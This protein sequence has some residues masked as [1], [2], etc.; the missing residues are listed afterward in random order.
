MYLHK[1][2]DIYTISLESY[3]KQRSPKLLKE[4]LY[5]VDRKIITP[6][7]MLKYQLSWP[8]IFARIQRKA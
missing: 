6:I 2:L 8:V 4:F 1:I 3:L 7:Q 5:V